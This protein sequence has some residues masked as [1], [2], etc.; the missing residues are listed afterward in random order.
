MDFVSTLRFAKRL[1]K[2]AALGGNDVVLVYDRVL[3]AKVPGFRAWARG[4]DR[5][6][7][8]RAGE[9][10]K[11]LRAFPARLE[12][13]LSLGDGL[14]RA[15]FTVVAVG[16]GSVGDFA[17]FAASVIKRG[18]RLVHVPS[19][20]LA[21]LDSAHG[22]K[23]ALNAAG[24][25]NQIGTFYPAETVWIVDEL[26]AGQGPRRAEEALGELVKMALLAGGGWAR[27]LF[28]ARSTPAKLLDPARLLSRYLKKAIDAKLAVVALDPEERTGR[29]EILNLGHTVGHVFEAAHGIP[30]GV[31]V[32]AGLRFALEWSWAEDLLADRDF[33]ALS[34]ALETLLPPLPR[35]KPLDAKSFERILRRD[36]KNASRD[37]L[38]FVF[39]EGLGRPLRLEVPVAAVVQEA[40]S[41]GWI[42]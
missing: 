8:V 34:A 27:R 2:A 23:T 30:H 42:E 41:Q 18:V 26:L 11:D 25:K 19:T 32:G 36:K 28:A 39:L 15:K 33:K 24:A 35:L 40:R 29:R 16:G 13:L 14:S 37:R 3:E 31:A 7:A 21:A 12:R 4:F 1:P 17:G 9:E 10:L 22:G 5:R 38:R 6:L 20:W